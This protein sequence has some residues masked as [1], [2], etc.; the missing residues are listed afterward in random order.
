MD[1]NCE[2]R[3]EIIKVRKRMGVEGELPGAVQADTGEFVDFE[4][5]WIGAYIERMAELSHLRSGGVRRAGR[6]RVRQS[7][8]RARPLHA[9]LKLPE[10]CAI[11]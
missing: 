7:A 2:S 10:D 11:E 5:R 1:F 9:R 4:E 8:P 6:L 3:K